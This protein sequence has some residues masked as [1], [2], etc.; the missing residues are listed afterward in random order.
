MLLSAETFTKGLGWW[1]EP[2]SVITISRAMQSRKP[3][4]T[5]ANISHKPFALICNEI[6]NCPCK[7]EQYYNTLNIDHHDGQSNLNSCPKSNSAPGSTTYKSKR[8]FCVTKEVHYAE[9]VYTW[10]TAED[11]NAAFYIN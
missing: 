5:R 6:V 3:Y 7:L 11:E 8:S 2:V 1:L 10:P 4:F 9:Q